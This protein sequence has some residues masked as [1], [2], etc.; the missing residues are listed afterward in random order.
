MRCG[1]AALLSGLA[2]AFEVCV[3]VSAGVAGVRIDGPHVTRLLAREQAAVGAQGGPLH[4]RR[5]GGL[6][7]CLLLGRGFGGLLLLLLLLVRRLTLGRA[8]CFR[9]ALSR[10]S[11][12][13]LAFRFAVVLAGRKSADDPEAYFSFTRGENA[14]RPDDK[15]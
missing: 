14:P 8:L 6:L 11:F 2:H 5:A 4:G 10:F 7:G 15:I 13:G 9:L 1:A 3:A 12:G